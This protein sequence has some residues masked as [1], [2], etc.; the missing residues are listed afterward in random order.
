MSRSHEKYSR[1]VLSPL[2]KLV[3]LLAEIEVANY[4]KEIKEE[5][6]STEN[7]ENESSNLRTL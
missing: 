6:Q 2:D 3:Y 7:A 4:M 1:R 5:E